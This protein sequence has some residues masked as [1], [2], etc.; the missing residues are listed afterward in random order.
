MDALALGDAGVGGDA[1]HQRHAV[2]H[3]H[4]KEGIRADRLDQLDTAGD[5]AGV[6]GT[7]QGDVLRPDADGERVV[8]KIAGHGAFEI[9]GDWPFEVE[10]APTDS[11]PP[12]DQVHRRTADEAGD[13]GVG[14][15][16]VDLLGVPTCCMTP[17]RMTTM[18][19]AMVIASIWSWVT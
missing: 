3:H 17:S 16:V 10:S 11:E 6:G 4:R 8:G 14:G 15:L 7:A 13:E 12:L 18:R 2:G 9:D 1:H 19:S 5:G